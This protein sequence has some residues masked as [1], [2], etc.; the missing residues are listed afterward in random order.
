MYLQCAHPKFKFAVVHRLHPSITS[1][2][3]DYCSAV[4]HENALGGSSRQ[5]VV[6]VSL[7]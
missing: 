6:Y 7:P 5:E 1:V 4:K 3:P 2:C